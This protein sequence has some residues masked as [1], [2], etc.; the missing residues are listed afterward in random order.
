MIEVEKIIHPISSQMPVGENLRAD[1][2]PASLYYAIKDKRSAA[3]SAE[4]AYL[5]GEEI[6]ESEALTHWKKVY[7]LAQTILLKHS[8]DLEICT[9]LIESALRIHQF[10]GLFKSLQLTKELISLY[11][12][13]IFPIA[14]D[15]D[16][17]KERTKISAL[18]SLNG[19]EAEGS[20]IAPIHH[21]LIT[22]GKSVVSFAFWQYKANDPSLMPEFQAS[23]SETSSDFVHHLYQN[24]CDCIETF[25]ALVKLIDE[26]CG[27]DMMP[28]SQILQALQDYK[29]GI[30]SVYETVITPDVSGDVELSEKQPFE[31]KA[32]SFKDRASAL[33]TLLSIADYFSKTEPHSPIPYILRRTVRWGNLAL[34]DL[35]SEVIRNEQARGEVFDLTGIEK[36]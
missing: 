36:N 17:D 10:E 34:P 4:R 23:V 19:E 35:L 16:E 27:R 1:I 11:W 8:K 12:E 22:Q 3:R 32:G 24:L 6:G 25:N 5:N 18:I 26:K 29:K 20:L 31:L 7:E 9:W 33:K 30:E 13:S 14:E 28:R 21:V 15:D 2:S